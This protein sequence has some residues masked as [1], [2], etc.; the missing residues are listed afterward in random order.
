VVVGCP[1][2]CRLTALFR[3]NGLGGQVKRL[4]LSPERN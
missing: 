2:V 3:I 4:N 1:A